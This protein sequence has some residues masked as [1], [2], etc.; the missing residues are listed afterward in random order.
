MSP[1]KPVRKRPCGFTAAPHGR[2]LHTADNMFHV[3]SASS[4]VP[5]EI[6]ALLALLSISVVVLLILRHYLPLRTTPTYYLVPIFFALWLPACM[7]L[8]VPV[9][10]ASSARTEDEA[11]RGIWLPQRVLLVSWR[12]TY[13]LTFALTWFILPILGEYSDSGYREPQDSLK[14]SL[15][16][17]AQYHLMV[18]GTA[19]VGLVYLFVR[20]QPDFTT[21]KTSF[22][23]LA[24]FYGLIFAIYLMGHGLVSIPRRLL[25]YSSISGRLRRLQTRA[26]Q[27]HEKM[28]DSLL[29]LEDVELQVSELGRRKTGSAVKFSE[30]IEELVEIAN[31]P[32]SQPR[33]GVGAESRALPTVITEKF[34][35]DLSRKLMRARHARSRYVNEWN[36]LLKEASDTQAI[37]DAAASKKLEFGTPSPHAGFWDRFTIH[38][39]YTRYLYYYHFEPYASIA[40]GVFLAAASTLI[41]WSEVIK[42]A[43]PQLSVIRLTV[44]HHWV[45]EKGQVGFAGQVI[46]VLWLLY[47]CSATFITMTEVKTWRG[48]ALVRRNTAYESAFWYAGQVAKLSV[49]LSYNFMTFLSSTIYTKTRFYGFLGQ[50]IDFT[51]MGEWADYLFPV[52]VLV[53]VAA[54]LFGLYGKIKRVFGFGGEFIDEDEGDGRT[55]GTG[56]WREGR[57]LIE[58][59]LGGN[60]GLRRRDEAF[61]RLEASGRSAPVLTIPGGRDG[62]AASPARSP[63]RSTNPR[64]GQASRAPYRDEPEEENF[65][66][67]LGHR[68]KNTIDTFEPPQWFQDIKKPKW[69]G[70]DDDEPSSSSGGGGGGGVD[71]DIR[72]WFGGEGRVRL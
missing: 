64:L 51:P 58:R 31:L 72:R 15:R 56:S 71:S 63:V 6:F 25:R 17:N 38:T 42:A 26:P 37:L 5:S 68:M 9:D 35:A 21:F 48:R 44:V 59:E 16:Q 62:A 67:S 29:N 14:Y 57:D 61:A 65:F 52:F 2:A 45:G 24:Y 60:S 70:G 8:L 55:F 54:T 28:E 18:L 1:D 66:E 19:S 3:V 34:M 20:Y 32:E 47:M 40:S 27:L 30:W 39:P 53:P 23:A 33:S 4:P 69:M 50:L 49:P 22:M 43:F 10:L 11:T 13:W 41:V 12:I 46:S 7:V 36:D